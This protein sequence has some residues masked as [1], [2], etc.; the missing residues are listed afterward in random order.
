M[1]Y[2]D[3]AQIVIVLVGILTGLVG[4]LVVLRKR[5]LFAQA[6]THATFP[7]A[8][9]AV[10]LGASM[11]LG[12]VIAAAALVLTLSLIGRVSP[13]SEQ[14][15]SG[16]MLT[17]GFALGVVL[18]ALNPSLP[19]NLEA[20]L[21]GSVL[22]TTWADAL[23]AGVAVVVAVIVLLIAGKNLLF[24]LFDQQ[25]YRAAGFSEAA[26]E[27]LLLTLTT[28]TVV[29]AMPAV[30][31]VLAIAL[32]AA[33]AA[34]ARL[35]SRSTTGMIILAPVIAVGSGLAGLWI[36]RLYSVSAGASIALVATAVFAVAYGIRAIGRKGS[37]WA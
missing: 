34:A 20:Y 17:G 37:V 22:A 33:P 15:A 6:L 1:S 35:L 19:L 5:V 3:R 29:V 24:F 2:F 14:A 32:I 10:T 4:S 30:G 7:G 12:A 36:S 13:K 21:F 26:M 11:Q 27:G 28:I 16:V 8:V 9:V 25:G 31:A 18:Q 23:L